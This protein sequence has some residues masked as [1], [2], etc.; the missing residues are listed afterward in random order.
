LKEQEGGPKHT[1]RGDE[2]R[3]ALIMAAYHIIAE[4]GFEGLRVRDVAAR[5]GLNI[6]TLHYY[7]ETKSDLV[8]GV[9]EY[10][11]HQFK[12]FRPA[13]PDIEDAAQWLRQEFI[14]LDY[15][16]KN[17]PEMFTV[18]HEIYVQARHDSVVNKIVREMDSQWHGYIMGICYKGVQTGVFRADLDPDRA[19]W[20][21]VA[22]ITGMQIVDRLGTVDMECL[23]NDILRGFINQS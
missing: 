2:R 3:Q 20:L 8:R 15:Q 21:I 11:L 14:D 10:M 5:V 18:L 7:F 13:A 4:K 23:V 6:A 19:S 9:V 17:S 1:A 12:T 22:L 16:V